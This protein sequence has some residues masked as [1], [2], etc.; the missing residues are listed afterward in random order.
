MTLKTKLKKAINQS[1]E[2][3]GLPNLIAK[4]DIIITNSK[5]NQGDYTTNIAF[6]ISQKLKKI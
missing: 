4:E 5:Q 3:V 2:S 6:I 1:I